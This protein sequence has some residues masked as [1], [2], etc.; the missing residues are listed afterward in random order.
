[1]LERRIDRIGLNPKLAISRR[2]VAISLTEIAELL[3]A[4]RSLLA[5]RFAESLDLL[6]QTLQFLRCV[7]TNAFSA[8]LSALACDNSDSAVCLVSL[9]RRR[10]SPI[11]ATNCE[12]LPFAGIGTPKSAKDAANDR[13]N[14]SC[15]RSAGGFVSMSRS[16]ATSRR[17][18][19]ALDVS[20]ESRVPVGAAARLECFGC[21]ATT[22]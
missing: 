16:R 4:E 21:G 2:E 1:V 10:P 18:G 3:P 8:A 19:R 17:A 20:T 15:V 12:K 6:P 5:Q 22:V 9:R 11:A 13:A 14:R 7:E